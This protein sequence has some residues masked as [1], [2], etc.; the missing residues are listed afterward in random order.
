MSSGV[1]QGGSV[2]FNVSESLNTGNKDHRIISHE[3]KEVRVE[4][5]EPPLT[6][7]KLSFNRNFLWF[8]W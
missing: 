2:W 4:W 6:H 5:F 7:D 1:I 8:L 3:F